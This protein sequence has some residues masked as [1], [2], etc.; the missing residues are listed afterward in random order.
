M[1]KRNFLRTWVAGMAIFLLWVTLPPA[2]GAAQVK[3]ITLKMTVWTPAPELNVYSRANSL[4]VREVEKRSGGRLKIEY[5]WSG[6]LIPAKET[7]SGLKTGVADLGFVHSG[8]EPGKL[9]LSTVASLPA[10]SHDYYPS[11]MAYGELHNMPEL[12]AEM[13]QQNIMYLSYTCNTSGGV[14]S[15]RPIRSLAEMKGKKIVCQ[16]EQATVIRALGAVPITMISTEV[17]Q[18]ME[19]GTADG[20]LANP[21][22]ASDYKWWDVAPNYFELLFGNSA[23]V[24]VAINKDSWNKI[25]ADLQKMFMDL[26]EESC[27]L[28]HDMYQ[29]NA[30]NQLKKQVAAKTVSHV[31]P[32]AADTAA[33][34]KA[35]KEV[36]WD[37]WADRMKER[38]LPGQKVLDAWQALYKK[39]DSQSPFKK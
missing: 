10:I 3:P 32:T 4:L 16:G 20:G 2:D 11:A 12:K 27:R 23:E 25:P 9:P 38:G 13:D 30:E 26:R 39:W 35:A 14:W 28:S 5:Y 34:A 31:K 33:V 21:G 19:K 15:R 24:M 18:A 17:F 22:Y 6:S 37:K 1:S 7:V 8:Y 29:S 36:V